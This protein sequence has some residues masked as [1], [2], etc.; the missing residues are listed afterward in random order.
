MN[1]RLFLAACIFIGVAHST[2]VFSQVQSPKNSLSSGYYLIVAAYKSNQES[3][4][5][6][7]VQELNQK[8]QH[9]SYGFDSGRK[10]YY[11]YLDRYN[12]FEE[13]L[14]RLGKTR[15]EGGFE[16]AWV[17]VMKVDGQGISTSPVEK[18]VVL[19]ETSK[20]ET[21][22]ETEKEAVVAVQEKPA[23]VVTPV[24]ASEVDDAGVNP[25]M[26]PVKLPH[27][28]TNTPVFLS[29]YSSVTNKVV[30]GEVQIVDIDRNVLIKK[31][32]GNDYLLLPDPKNNTG[33]MMLVAEAFG[34]RKEQKEINF[35]QQITQGSEEYKDM[36]GN[37]ILVDFDL[38][39]LRK[40]DMATLFNV[41]FYNDAAVMLPESQ[42]ELNGLLAM[43]EEKPYKIILHGHTNGNSQGKI[44]TMG[45][46]KN[47]FSLSG[48]VKEG[49]GSSKELSKERAETIKEW[50]VA[51]GIAED[52]IA[53]KAWGGGKMIHDKHSVNAKKNVRVDVEVVSE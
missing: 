11:V 2:L 4:A 28:M 15:R 26:E 41:Y 19:A 1:S 52:R 14:G 35:K 3:F 7:Y 47:F 49:Y 23:E 42:Y 40:G 43:M 39:R 22:I 24:S 36:F 33:K 12:E 9:A 30:P 18:P 50:L 25:K 31:V 8:G 34:Y 20:K 5:D 17:R 27:T 38:I 53:I 44:I 51:K 10:M 29:L 32:K 6:K 21:P 46:D 16:N 48:D 13:S 37:F 45:P